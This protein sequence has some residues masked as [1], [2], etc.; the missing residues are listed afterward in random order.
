MKNPFLVGEKIYLRPIELDD[1]AAM[2][3]WMNDTDVTRSLKVARPMNLDSE[4]AFIE[5]VTRSP[6]TNRKKRIL[7]TPFMVK[8]AALILERSPVFT[9]ECS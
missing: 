2:V 1:A 4:R 8:K 6:R 5:R 3:P 9:S 7:M